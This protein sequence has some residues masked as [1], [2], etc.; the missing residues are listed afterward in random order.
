MDWDIIDQGDPTCVHRNRTVTAKTWD[1][2]DCGRRIV[3]DF[4]APEAMTA[5][6]V[7]FSKDVDELER[8][9]AQLAELCSKSLDVAVVHAETR[10]PGWVWAVRNSSLHKGDP[11]PSAIVAPDAEASSPSYQAFGD[12]PGEALVAAVARAV[13][14]TENP[15]K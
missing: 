4:G 7:G 9:R 13:E 11:R 12:T 2:H 6:N 8:A 5:A 1:C 10:L 3:A 15:S 14:A